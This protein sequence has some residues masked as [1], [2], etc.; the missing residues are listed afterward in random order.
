VTTVKLMTIIRRPSALLP[1]CA[2][3]SGVSGTL[4]ATAAH[5]I[6]GHAAVRDG[7]GVGTPQIQAPW[8]QGKGRNAAT[9]G[10]TFK[11]SAVVKTA[12]GDV[13]GIRPR[14]RPV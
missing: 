4:A 7:L 14:G 2:P 6:V 1:V 11:G 9:Y 13:R 5:A 8:A 10:L 3:V 12:V